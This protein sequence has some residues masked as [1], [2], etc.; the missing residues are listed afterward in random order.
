MPPT[1]STEKK[2]RGKWVALVV[3]PVVLFAGAGIAIGLLAG[4]PG[5]HTVTFIDEDYGNSCSATPVGRGAPVKVTGDNGTQLATGS[6]NAGTDGSASLTDGSTIPTCTF[7]AVIQVPANQ[8]TYSF[9]DNMNSNSVA[10]TRQQ[11]QGSGWLA[12]ITTNQP[13]NLAGGTPTVPATT[14]PPVTATVQQ[15]YATAYA[16]L[17]QAINVWNA[18][19]GPFTTAQDDALAAAVTTYS[20]AI[21]ELGATGQTEVDIRSAVAAA[22]TLAGLAGVGETNDAVW[23][24]TSAQ[25]LT[26]EDAIAADLS[27]G[28]STGTSS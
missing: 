19:P 18:L 2:G 26:A 10:F 9:D 13:S 8:N 14:A 16:A 21:S 17:Q 24:T 28:G 25:L 3:I 5:N 15:G 20:N 23:T 22:N 27:P 1:P 11:L 4:G 7:R 6:L 12:S